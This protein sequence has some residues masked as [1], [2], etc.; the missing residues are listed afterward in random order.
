MSADLT[1]VPLEAL[2]IVRS[3]K[4]EHV[5]ALIR[6]GHLPEPADG[7]VPPDYLPLE[8][9]PPPGEPPEW[10]GHVDR[11]LRRF[12]D[13]QRRALA[14][15]VPGRERQREQQLMRMGSAA[16]GAGLS[17]LMQS[18][19]SEA[20][21]CL[22]R[23]AALYRHSLVDA[24]PGMWGRS[25]GSLKARLLAGDAP[26]ALREGRWTLELG[27]LDSDSTIALYAGVL[28]LLTL[29][30]DAS[31]P[32]VELK[33]REG[34]PTA[35][36]EAVAALADGDAGRYEPAVRAV[37]RSFE[38]RDRYLENVPVA[39]TVLVLQMLAVAR[40]IAVSLASPLL[41]PQP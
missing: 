16:W 11:E 28:S 15:F 36:A 37:L 41:P 20:L 17:F 26:G 22:E 34:F 13:G 27:A 35:T 30:E 12:R 32:A 7:L 29:G 19:R 1:L 23:A 14:A 31:G 8:P 40:G 24:E 9:D 5:W 10:Q 18:R 4:P 25:I 21:L 6:A 33:A 3:T 39:D 38:E 2:C